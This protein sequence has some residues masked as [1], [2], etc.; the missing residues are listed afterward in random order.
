MLLELRKQKGFTLLELLIVI[1]IIGILIALVLPNLING[2]IKARDVSRKENLNA[3]SSGLEQYY[4]DN[5]AYPATITQLTAGT[6]PYLKEIPKDPKTQTDYVYTA[7]PSGGP[8]YTSFT[9]Q[10]K[11]EN[12]NDKEINVPPETYQVVNKQ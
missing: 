10:A 3:I 11:L 12:K 8:I 5:S 7:L 2:P 4:N 1:V 9:L 6:P